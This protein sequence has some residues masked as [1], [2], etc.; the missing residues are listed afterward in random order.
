MDRPFRI[1]AVMLFTAIT[2]LVAG[3]LA[4]GTQLEFVAMMAER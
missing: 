3:E 2:F 1:T 4:A